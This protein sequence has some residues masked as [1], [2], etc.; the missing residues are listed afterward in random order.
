[1]LRRSKRT[2]AV[3]SVSVI[4]VFAA[5]A[6]VVTAVATGA[7]EDKWQKGANSSWSATSSKTTFVSSVLTITCTSNTAGAPAW[8]PG[9][10]PAR[11][12]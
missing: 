9:P 8:G 5:G 2:L 6:A 12:R 4:S 11:W 1:M 3:L 10:M 7:S